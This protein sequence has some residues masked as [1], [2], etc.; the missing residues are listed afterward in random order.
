MNSITTEM[1]MPEI[2]PEMIAMYKF[3]IKQVNLTQI[4]IKHG[5]TRDY[6][7][8]FLEGKTQ[9]VAKRASIVQVLSEALAEYNTAK[10]IIE[11]ALR[12]KSA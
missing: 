7:Y 5:V 1:A 9:R 3:A 2:T 8:K 11:N 6:V 4:C 12:Q 10:T